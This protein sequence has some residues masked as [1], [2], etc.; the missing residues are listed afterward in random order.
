MDNQSFNISKELPFPSRNVHIYFKILCNMSSD[1]IHMYIYIHWWSVFIYIYTHNIYI[2]SHMRIWWMN[3][4]WCCI[5]ISAQM[6]HWRSGGTQ[7][8][9]APEQLGHHVTHDS[10]HLVF[11]IEEM[12]FLGGGNPKVIYVQLKSPGKWSILTIIFFN[13]V[14]TTN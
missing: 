1:Y 9:V 11:S 7:G 14:E 12:L 5:S 4:V 3:S 2:S 6:L 8:Y 10:H 13:W